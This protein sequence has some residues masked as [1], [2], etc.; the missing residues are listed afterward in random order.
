[1]QGRK[2]EII[3]EV[4]NDDEDLLQDFVSIITSFCT[5]IYGKRRSKRNTERLIKELNND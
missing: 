3:N 5:R 2:L 4:N 1:M